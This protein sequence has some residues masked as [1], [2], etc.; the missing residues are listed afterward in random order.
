MQ[1]YSDPRRESDPHAL[2]DLEVFYHNHEDAIF[3]VNGTHPTYLDGD[4][5]GTGWYWQACFPGCL[6]DGDANGPFDSADS[7]LADARSG[8]AFDPDAEE[9]V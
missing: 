8:Y 6:P 5:P 9:E 2:P 1:A 7:A 3:L 4:C